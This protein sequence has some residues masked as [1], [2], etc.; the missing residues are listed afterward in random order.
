MRHTCRDPAAQLGGRLDAC[1]LYVEKAPDWLAGEVHEPSVWPLERLVMLRRSNAGH[2]PLALNPAAHVASHHESQA[3]EHPSLT[4]RA[5]RRE[6]LAD[7]FSEHLAISHTQCPLRR[8]GLMP[9]PR[10]RQQIVRRHW[11]TGL[12]LTL[13]SDVP[14]LREVIVW[15]SN[16]PASCGRELAY[17]ESVLSILG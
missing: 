14:D 4:H 2:E 9:E 5:L 13:A 17:A 3:A 7:P 16:L 6:Q 10:Q 15:E 12:S 11:N 1:R 8:C